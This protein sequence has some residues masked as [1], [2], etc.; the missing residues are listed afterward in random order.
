[1]AQ[2]WF[3]ISV[4]AFLLEFVPIFV[5][6][7]SNLSNHVYM[8]QGLPIW[9][10]G[11]KKFPKKYL[12]TTWYFKFRDLLRLY[13]SPYYC[14]P[15]TAHLSEQVRSCQLSEA[16]LS[17]P[18]AKLWDSSLHRTCFFFL[19]HSPVAVSFT[20]AMHTGVSDVRPASSCS[21]TETPAPKFVLQTLYSTIYI[22]KNPHQWKKLYLIILCFI[23]KTSIFNP[24]S[25]AIIHV[26]EIPLRFHWQ[27]P[28][29][30]TKKA[31]FVP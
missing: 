14:S 1:M 26:F 29:Q 15:T 13:T 7:R 11:G 8:D 2:I 16:R 21:A 5:C 31:T 30:D 25:A 3:H 10:I 27:F 22:K 28:C 9:N 17:H 18:T 20:S 4:D 6:V 23:T 19:C 12:G 24:I